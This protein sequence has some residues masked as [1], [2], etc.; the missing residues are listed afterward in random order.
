MLSNTL[1]IITYT[2]HTYTNHTQGDTAMPST[3]RFTKLIHAGEFQVICNLDSRVV[4]IM[5]SGVSD[6]KCAYRKEC[7][8]TA[9][10]ALTAYNK[11]TTLRSD[12]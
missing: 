1:T 11:I 10:L 9:G 7:Y 12:M 6:V 4:K 3:S 5:K 8:D 2:V